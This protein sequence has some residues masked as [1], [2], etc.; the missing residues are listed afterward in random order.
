MCVGAVATQS[1]GKRTPVSAFSF[2]QQKVTSADEGRNDFEPVG[3]RWL[4]FRTLDTLDTEIGQP[5][6]NAEGTAAVLLLDLQN[7]VNV[8]QLSTCGRQ[9]QRVTA[10][11]TDP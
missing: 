7:L 9:L 10:L 11:D 4:V 6:L 1:V 2:S 3:R 5:G 8:S